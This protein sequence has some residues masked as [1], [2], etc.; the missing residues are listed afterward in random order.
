MLRDFS[1]GAISSPLTCRFRWAEDPLAPFFARSD[2][3]SETQFLQEA[4]ILAGGVASRRNLSLA[5]D[6]QALMAGQTLE[7][8]AVAFSLR[9]RDAWRLLS[10]PDAYKYIQVGMW[11][12]DGKIAAQRIA[13]I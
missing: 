8:A 6:P 12:V 10:L 9:E 7:V 13:N 5:V 1:V 11:L 4:K 2:D 3:F